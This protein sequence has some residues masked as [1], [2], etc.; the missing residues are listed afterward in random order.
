MIADI[1]D[2]GLF[3][4]DLADKQ[5]E[6]LVSCLDVGD[7]SYKLM[8]EYGFKLGYAAAHA[9]PRC[10]HES[11]GAIYTSMPPKQKCVKCGEFY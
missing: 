6:E 4:Q 7:L 10:E 9:V 1:I 8:L 11:D 2:L 5:L 3:D